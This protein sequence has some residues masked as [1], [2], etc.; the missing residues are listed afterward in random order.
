MSCENAEP[1]T[2]TSTTE[3]L[4]RSEITEALPDT[5]LKRLLGELQ[6]GGSVANLHMMHNTYQKDNS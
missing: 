1:V 2:E 3:Q 5:E 6:Q 4:L